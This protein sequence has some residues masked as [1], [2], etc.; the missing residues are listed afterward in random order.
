[1]RGLS[2]GRWLPIS[3]SI[4]WASGDPCIHVDGPS[5]TTP[6]PGAAGLVLLA[7]MTG[8]YALAATRLTNR[9]VT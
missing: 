1:V 5:G 8:L 4:A 7:V 6:Q 3:N 2:A 9:D